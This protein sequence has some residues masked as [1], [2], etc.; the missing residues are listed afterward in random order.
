[1][2][3]MPRTALL[4]PLAATCILSLVVGA[5]PSQLLGQSNDIPPLLNAPDDYRGVIDL[6]ENGLELQQ[7]RSSEFDAGNVAWMVIASMSC[8]FLIT[9][10]LLFFYCGLLRTPNAT[11]VM[12]R[13]IGLVALL[14]MTWGLWIYSLAFARNANSHD[15]LPSERMTPVTEA[16]RPAGL[17]G[18]SNHFGF[19]G[20]DSQ[21]VD[22]VPDYPLRRRF[23]T[24]PHLLFMTCQM[25]FFVSVPVP[26]VVALQGRLTDAGM[27]CFVVL[28]GTI[29]YAPITYWVWGGGWHA[30]ALDT[31]GGIVA[32]TTAGF[33]VLGAAWVLRGEASRVEGREFANR[34][35]LGAG[36]VLFWSG[37]LIWNASH[38]LAAD[39]YAINAFVTTHLAACAGLIGWIGADW[40]TRGKVGRIGLCAGPIVGLVSIAS[41]SGYVAPQ[42][43]IVI[44]L[45]GGAIACCAYGAVNRRFAGNALLVVFALQAICGVLGTLLAGVFATASVAGFDQQGNAIAGLIVGNPERL[46]GQASAVVSAAILATF[47]TLASLLIVRFTCG[48]VASR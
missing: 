5:C 15:I 33:S 13:Y 6:A 25:M 38:S 28:W 45:L 18:N 8:L 7:F 30:A 14:S 22:Q 17:L 4:T 12:I 19:R 46:A 3:F 48:L 27:A 2:V 24:V 36:V 1:M 11:I 34:V 29:V 40:L 41:G 9:P 44:G 16:N 26:L 10:G 35:Y 20:L 39:G 32:H 21:L 23:D 37:S 43:S 47:G 31:G 42:S